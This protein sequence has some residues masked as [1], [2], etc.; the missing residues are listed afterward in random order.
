MYLMSCRLFNN[1]LSVSDS[2][3]HSIIIKKESICK[4]FCGMKQLD[5]VLCS[6][7]YNSIDVLLEKDDSDSISHMEK[8]D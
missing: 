3:T 2:S 5:N 1:I 6:Y 4:Y 8:L 7:P